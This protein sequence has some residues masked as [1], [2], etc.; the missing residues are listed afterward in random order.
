MEKK[1]KESYRNLAA[2][3]SDGLWEEITNHKSSLFK[4]G[5]FIFMDTN[6]HLFHLHHERQSGETMMYINE[7]VCSA[8]FWTPEFVPGSEGRRLS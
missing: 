5:D 4:S 8:C 1:T 2:A 3:P 7:K 6:W